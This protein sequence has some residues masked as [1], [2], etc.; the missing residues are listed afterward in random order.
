MDWTQ[1][2]VSH[3][4]LD[5]KGLNSDKFGTSCDTHTVTSFLQDFPELLKVLCTGGHSGAEQAYP[6]CG[7]PEKSLTLSFHETPNSKPQPRAE[8]GG[9][10]LR[11]KGGDT[12]F[13]GFLQAVDTASFC[14]EDSKSLSERF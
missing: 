10:P 3:E 14:P 8:V 2:C 6:T 9:G 11:G 7:P 12:G 1:C 5:S 4:M 13:L